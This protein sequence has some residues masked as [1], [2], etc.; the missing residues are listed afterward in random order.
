[1][2]WGELLLIAIFGICFGFGVYAF[3]KCRRNR[4]GAIALIIVSIIALVATLGLSS[5]SAEP[6]DYNQSYCE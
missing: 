5:I 1:M 4:A 2:F 3:Q 6:G